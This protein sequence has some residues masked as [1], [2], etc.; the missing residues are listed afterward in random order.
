MR[1]NIYNY[2]YILF[3]LEKFSFINTNG[4]GIDNN[5]VPNCFVINNDIRNVSELN[6][7]AYDQIVP[8][9]ILEINT[10]NKTYGKNNSSCN[11]ILQSKIRNAYNIITEI[12]I[13]KETSQGELLGNQNI[14]NIKVNAINNIKELK[15]FKYIIIEVL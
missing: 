3:D 15:E 5:N 8:N 12:L 9:K 13:T 6:I 2:D 14:E 4:D 7:K 11:E 10:T 1:I